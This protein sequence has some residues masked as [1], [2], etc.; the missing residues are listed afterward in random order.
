M[1]ADLI[2]LPAPSLAAWRP[3]LRGSWAA[4][5]GVVLCKF[6]EGFVNR[7]SKHIIGSLGHDQK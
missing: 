5:Q 7:R 4:F 2:H 3:D 6:G 1:R